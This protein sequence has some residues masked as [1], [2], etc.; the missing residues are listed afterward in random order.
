MRLK[1]L[2]QDY[3]LCEQLPHLVLISLAKR[4]QY[5]IISYSVFISCNQLPKLYHQFLLVTTKSFSYTP[6]N[7]T[8]GWR[9]GELKFLYHLRISQCLRN[10]IH[11]PFASSTAN[12]TGKIYR[13]AMLVS[14][15][16]FIPFSFINLL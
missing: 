8:S 14:R 4:C 11:E 7:S 2:I 3:N 13:S 12:L 16:R 5:H 15:S 6:P 10:H 1:Q 9:D